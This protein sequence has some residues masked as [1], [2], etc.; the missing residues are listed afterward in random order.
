MLAVDPAVASHMIQRKPKVYAQRKSDRNAVKGL[1]DPAKF[2]DDK[3]RHGS[4]PNTSDPKPNAGAVS[5]ALSRRACTTIHGRKG[6][7]SEHCSCNSK[8]SEIKEAENDSMG[9]T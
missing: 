2:H 7:Q 8:S 9:Q 3:R 5:W 1:T 4:G 6:K